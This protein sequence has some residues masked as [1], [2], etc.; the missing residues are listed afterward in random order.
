MP[1]TRKS[2]IRRFLLAYSQYNCVRKITPLPQGVHGTAILS[3]SVIN[4]LPV[5]SPQLF[6]LTPDPRWQN[7]SLRP[8]AL[9]LQQALGQE[10][11]HIRQGATPASGAE[12][13]GATASGAEASGATVSGATASGATASGIS[14]RLLQAVAALLN[15]AHSGA[16]VMAMHRHHFI[17]CPIMR[18]LYQYHVSGFGSISQRG[19]GEMG[20]LFGSI[21]QRGVRE[22]QKSSVHLLCCV[23]TL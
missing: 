8:L 10:L 9:A 6:P 13:S 16:L 4:V 1:G 2:C 21:S 22:K 17:S 23:H 18:Q 14:M 19:V 12:P 5:V 7:S 20:N 15:S 3:L 11:A